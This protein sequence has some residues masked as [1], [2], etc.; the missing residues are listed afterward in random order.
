MYLVDS[1]SSELVVK[2]SAGIFFS[3]CNI[4]I[5]CLHQ[6]VRRY[7]FTFHWLFRVSVLDKFWSIALNLSFTMFSGKRSATVLILKHFSFVYI[8][9]VWSPKNTDKLLGIQSFSLNRPVITKTLM[10][11]VDLSW[12]N[13]TIIH[14][15]EFRNFKIIQNFKKVHMRRFLLLASIHQLSLLKKV[16]TYLE[17][18]SVCSVSLNWPSIAS[19]SI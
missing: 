11:M 3:S 12:K 13:K 10:L 1:K 6:I 4:K 15:T 7:T 2:V 16:I 14:Q 9:G 8:E 5:V 17:A 19:I 18:S